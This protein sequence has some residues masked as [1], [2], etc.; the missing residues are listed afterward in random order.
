MPKRT[1]FYEEEFMGCCGI[2]VIFEFPERAT[3]EDIK[4]FKKKHRNVAKEWGGICITLNN[5]QEAWEPVLLSLG[6]TLSASGVLN[7]N[8]GNLISLYFYDCKNK[9]REEDDD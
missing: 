1:W 3:P 7:P 2:C 4:D 9:L 5:F 6:Y 8:T